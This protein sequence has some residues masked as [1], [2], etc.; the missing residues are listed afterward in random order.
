MLGEMTTSYYMDSG[1]KG[2]FP[3]TP[4]AYV[5]VSFWPVHLKEME[6]P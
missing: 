3:L 4:I 5:C 2:A 6:V 1:K